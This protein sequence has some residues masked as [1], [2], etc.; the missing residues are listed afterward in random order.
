[1]PLSVAEE[2]SRASE[3]VVFYASRDEKGEMW[4][5][6]SGPSRPCTEFW[7]N[8]G[9]DVLFYGC[10]SLPDIFILLVCVRGM[11]Q[12]CRNVEGLVA[13]AFAMREGAIVYVGARAE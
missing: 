13:S 12:D 1:M 6:V 5:P 3:F 2:A 9:D 8:W 4:C 10:C 11:E 7:R